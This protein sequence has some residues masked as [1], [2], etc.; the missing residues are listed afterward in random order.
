MEP[1][2]RRS[3]ALTRLNSATY[4]LVLLCRGLHG[5]QFDTGRRYGPIDAIGV[6]AHEMWRL[7]TESLSV[8]RRIVSGR[9][10]LASNV[11]SPIVIAQYANATAQM[12]LAAFLSFLA[13]LSLSLGI[14]NLLPIP[15]LDGGHLLY[16]LME[17]I[18]GRP[19]SERVLVTGQY[20]G[21][22]LL[23]ALMCFAFYNDLASIFPLSSR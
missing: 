23:A 11:H 14:M 16:Y 1:A 4:G 18:S 17:L 3:E 7:T 15:V 22:A 9:A 19:V 13:I 8:L 12:G 21:L 6:A 20:V 2:T 10:S 5:A